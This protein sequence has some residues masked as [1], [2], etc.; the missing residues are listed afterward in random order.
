M[1]VITRLLS[2]NNYL[3]RIADIATSDESYWK[4]KIEIYF[5]ML[6]HIKVESW[7]QLYNSI[8]NVDRVNSGEKRHEERL[9]VSVSY[10]NVDML[11]LLLHVYERIYRRGTGLVH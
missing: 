5:N 8:I 7:N 3:K 1:M 4:R 6:I 9:K 11:N 10:K 2:K